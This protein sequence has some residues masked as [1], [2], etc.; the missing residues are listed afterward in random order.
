MEKDRKSDTGVRRQMLGAGKEAGGWREQMRG[1]DGKISG[2]AQLVHSTRLPN[3]I[4]FEYGA[5]LWLRAVWCLSEVSLHELLHV[6]MPALFNTAIDGRLGLELPGPAPLYIV[7]ID[8]VRP[9]DVIPCPHSPCARPQLLADDH[10]TEVPILIHILI[11]VLR[12]NPPARSRRSQVVLDVVSLIVTIGIWVEVRASVHCTE[13]VL[14]TCVLRGADIVG[15]QKSEFEGLDV[16]FVVDSLGVIEREVHVERDG[17]LPLHCRVESDGGVCDGRAS[18]CRRGLEENEG[19]T[20]GQFLD[21]WFAT[22][23]YLL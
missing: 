20:L 13:D 17:G 9:F 18:R 4:L 11:H 3:A 7:S 12:C 22:A 19:S 16:F 23:W 6:H 21:M 10:S 14:D 2:E 15:R 5:V 1:Y 8:P